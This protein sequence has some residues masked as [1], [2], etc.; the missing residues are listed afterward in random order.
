MDE[1]T[2]LVRTG[3]YRQV[4]DRTE[5]VYAETRDDAV[6]QYPAPARRYSPGQPRDYHGRFTFSIGP[7]QTGGTVKGAK[8]QGGKGGGGLTEAGAK[9]L[10][11]SI[12][13][14]GGF[15]FDPRKGGLVRV[16]D[17]K[18]Y[19][20]AVPHTEHIVGQGARV[21][22]AE[23][24]KGVTGVI[25]KYGPQLAKGH[26]LGGWYSPERK[27]YMVELTQVVKGRNAAVKLGQARNQEGIF[28]LG[29]GEY[30]PTGGTGG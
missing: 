16:G 29:T 27:A 3:A 21:S 12:H 30:I 11:K 9:D 19:A 25:Q 18:G 24:V 1:P 26:F 8:A 28:D 17:V 15:T 22:R 4:G 2:R 6:E 20:V 5:P 13:E 14:S 23:F 7:G 10:I